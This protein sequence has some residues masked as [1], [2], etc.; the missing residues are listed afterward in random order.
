MAAV[1]PIAVITGIIGFLKLIAKPLKTIDQKID[2]V[3]GKV[4][5]VDEKV[6]GVQED[7]VAV[8]CHLLNQAH[9]YYLDKG[10]CPGDIKEQLSL[11]CD[12]YT[13]KGHNHIRPRYRDTLIALDEH[14]PGN[15]PAARKRKASPRKKAR[16]N[17]TIPRRYSH[18]KP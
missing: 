18:A 12:T 9:D 5:A 11:M 3:D 15:P 14:P 17:R 7:M 6:G 2:K 13:Q 8:Q 10:W 16:L 1:D 4:A